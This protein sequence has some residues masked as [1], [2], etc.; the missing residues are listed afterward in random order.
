MSEVQRSF[1]PLQLVFE[2]GKETIE[3][4]AKTGTESASKSYENIV[5][6][7]KDHV[8]SAVKAADSAFK[9]YSEMSALGKDTADAMLAAGNAMAKGFESIARSWF[10]FGKQSMESHVGAAKDAMGTKNLKDYME[11]Q[12]QFARQQ[13][14]AAFA[15]VTKLSELGVKT[16]QEA[17]GPLTER[18][19]VA[20]EKMLKQVNG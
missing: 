9:S 1:A 5:Q 7:G 4:M 12:S 3:Q 2:R 10:A 16:T 18:F 11:W 19:N 15:E 14:D 13:F 20:V 17:L 8:D 6:L